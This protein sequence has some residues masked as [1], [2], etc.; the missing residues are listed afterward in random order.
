MPIWRRTWHSTARTRLECR[1]HNRCKAYLHTAGF[2]VD[3]LLK[4]WCDKGCNRDWTSGTWLGRWFYNRCKAYLHTAGF[5][6]DTLLKMW[7]DKGCNRDRTDRTFIRRVDSIKRLYLCCRRSENKKMWD[8]RIHWIWR[9][10]YRPGRSR[11]GRG[12]HNR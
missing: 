12:L 1:I 8:L 9:Y 5:K 11:V 6:V 3:T 10:R 7:C 2:K 4:M